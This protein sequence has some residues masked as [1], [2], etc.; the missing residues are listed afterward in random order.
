MGSAETA[1][2]RAVPPPLKKRTASEAARAE[3]CGEID[4][5]VTADDAARR[6]VD[7]LVARLADRLA[8]ERE[9]LTAERV[10][11]EV[12]AREEIDAAVRAIEA[13]A[14]A[15]RATRRNTS[16]RQREARRRAA[17]A[18]MADAIA[19]YVDIVGRGQ[20]GPG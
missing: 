3:T 4:A 11:T 2:V 6:D 17:A 18:P 15:R 14:D 1:A 16:E 20:G 19:A 7:A 12:R 8:A 13:D 9:R 10:A 5:V